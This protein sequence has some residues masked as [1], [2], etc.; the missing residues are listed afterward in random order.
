MPLAEIFVLL[1][2]FMIYLVEEGTHLLLRACHPKKVSVSV[3]GDKV[4]HLHREHSH[5]AEEIAGIH[6]GGAGE[7]SFEATMRGFV[8][9]LALSL[10]ALFEGVALGLT[11]SIK[12]VWFIFFA[13]ASHK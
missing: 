10:H 3:N 5:G 6:A 12:S 8:V 13:I 2:F 11:G 9:V 7:S 1:G 4:P